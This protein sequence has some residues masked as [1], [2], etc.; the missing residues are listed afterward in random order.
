MPNAHPGENVIAKGKWTNDAKYGKT[1]EGKALEAR[2][3]IEIPDMPA[4]INSLEKFIASFSMVKSSVD[5]KT[6]HRLE[7][8]AA[9]H[10][11]EVLEIFDKP[12]HR[13]LLLK[14]PGL[15]PKRVEEFGFEWDEMRDL[16]ELTNFLH[17]ARFS[18]EVCTRGVPLRF[19]ML[20]GLKP[21]H[22]CDPITCLSNVQFLTLTTTNL[23]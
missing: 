5:A 6:L 12:E 23:V 7:Y 1:L 18:A 9:G 2:A 16:R 22:T 20:L 15:S 3:P 11:V 8:I 17:G 4:S 14:L 19:T 10:D 13:H 21:G